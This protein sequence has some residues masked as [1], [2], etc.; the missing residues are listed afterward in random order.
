MSIVEMQ[1]VENVAVL[2]LNFPERLNAISIDMQ[3]ALREGLAKVKAD[4]TVK[5]LVITGEGRSFSVGADLSSIHGLPSDADVGA[6]MHEWMQAVSI[7]LIQELRAVPVATVCAVNGIAAGAGV[8]LALCG[9]VVVASRSAYFYLPFV[10][11]LGLIPD[12]GCTWALLKLAGLNRAMAMTLL[13][14]KIDAERA[15]KYGLIWEVCDDGALHKR[16]LEIAARLA[17]LPP[18]AVLEARAAFAHAQRA[19][20]NEQLQYEAERQMHLA[21]TP[22]FQEGVDAFLN[23]R[24]ASFSAMPANEPI[25]EVDA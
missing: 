11:R 2:K 12:L 20:L 17:D 14:E 9:D 15:E 25:P 24:K 5:A 23:K 8:G 22:A 19:T 21:R 13:D 10:P 16:A 1:R 7:P 3:H 18:G 4:R 6:Q